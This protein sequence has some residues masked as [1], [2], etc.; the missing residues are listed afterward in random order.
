MKRLGTSTWPHS[1]P[2]WARAM[3]SKRRTISQRYIPDR[4]ATRSGRR[5]A[6]RLYNEARQGLLRRSSP[7]QPGAGYRAR[8]SAL[9]CGQASAQI[10]ASV[11][12]VNGKLRFDNNRPLLTTTIRRHADSSK[13]LSPTSPPRSGHHMKKRLRI[14]IGSRQAGYGDRQWNE[15]LPDCG[16][17]LATGAGGYWAPG[18]EP[19]T[20][21]TA[22]VRGRALACIRRRLP[23][24][25]RGK[26]SSG[27]GVLA[28]IP[29]GQQSPGGSEGAWRPD[30]LAGGRA[31][32]GWETTGGE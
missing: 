22:R 9:V 8:K 18:V 20:V 10:P 27:W 5:C 21:V 15:P 6:N 29:V 17:R 25:E 3:S 11:P 30:R 24:P 28:S 14:T 31:I 7:S 12:P 13:T 32:P 4:S 19:G 1:R 2:D 26:R 23:G 16:G